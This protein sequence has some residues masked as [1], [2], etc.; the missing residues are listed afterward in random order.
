MCAIIE[1]LINRIT[2]IAESEG[3]NVNVEK[4]KDNTASFEFSKYTPAGQDFSFTIELNDDDTNGFIGAVDDFYESFDIDAE[5]YLWI[6]P[7]GHGKHGAPYHIKDILA[8]ME[9]VE[10]MLGEL[11]EAFS[12]LS[13]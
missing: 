10:E 8:D 6:N 9:K 11:S 5:T 1:E 4:C 3:W 2:E 12:I 13:L 7:D